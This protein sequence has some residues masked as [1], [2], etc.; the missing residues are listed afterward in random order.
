MQL[1]FEGLI[2]RSRDGNVDE[3]RDERRGRAK[4]GTG[5]FGYPSQQHLKGG[6]CCFSTEGWREIVMRTEVFL[7]QRKLRVP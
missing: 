5:S 3:Y 4:G 7:D 2:L 6:D 1:E